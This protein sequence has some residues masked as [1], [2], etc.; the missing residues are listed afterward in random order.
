MNN[1][2]FKALA[3]RKGVGHSLSTPVEWGGS[4]DVFGCKI[5]DGDLIQSEKRS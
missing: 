1:V 5:K 4:V 2:G 3:A